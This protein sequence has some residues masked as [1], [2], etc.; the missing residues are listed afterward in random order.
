MRTAVRPHICLSMIVRNE[1][2][3]I[4]RCLTS[5]APIV[6]AAVLCDTGSTDETVRRAVACLAASNRPAAVVA[7]P[8]RDFG[9]NRT[10]ALKTARAFAWARGWPLERTYLLFLDADFELVVSSDFRYEQLQADA[11]TMCQ[12]SDSVSFWSLRLARASLDWRVVGATHEHYASRPAVRPERLESLWIR[13]HEDGGSRADK[14]TRDIRLLTQQLGANPGDPRTLFYLAQSYRAVG[15]AIKAL[16]LYRRR[17]ALG[18]SPEEVWYSKFAIGA[19][20][21]GAGDLDQAT[22]ALLDAA[23]SDPERAE[24]W[25]A[26]ATL[27]R[28]HGR[29]EEAASFADRGR[30]LPIPAARNAFIHREVYEG[31][32]DLELARAAAG[33]SRHEAGF[34][35]CE[36]LSLSRSAP[37]AVVDEA[38]RLELSYVRPLPGARFL[39][40]HPHLPAPYRPCNPGI[41]R[42]RDGYLVNCRAVNY[43]QRRLRYRP[44]HDDLVYRTENVLMSLDAEFEVLD[45]RLITIDAPPLRETRIRGLEDCRLVHV[46]GALFLMAATTDRHPSG[47][48]HQSLCHVADD[49]RVLS[50]LPLVGPFD[51]RVQKNWLPCAGPDGRLH[52]FYGYDPVTVLEVSAETGAYA[53]STSRAHGLNAGHWRGSAG[54]VVWPGAGGGRL[55]LLVHEAVPRQ[56]PDGHRDRVYLHRFVECDAGFAITRISRPFVFAHKGVEFAC[57]MAVTHD[58]EALVIGVGIEDRDACL[59]RLPITSVDALLRR[60]SAL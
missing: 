15:D 24:P 32:L 48:V 11:L 16:L 45:E 2:A 38:R 25:H 33:T 6:D 9:A 23:A 35:A 14:F 40:L 20:F 55:L 36:R 3:T 56:G 49:G 52:A 29:H 51:D 21:M 7:H 46:N 57:G 30:H 27:Y 34:D 47:R 59:C 42:T 22:P 53:V 1:Q 26:L 60:E 37:A 13:D 58:R 17:I 10:A 4:E 50:H 19:M 41:V 8:W 28:R 43:E 39:S 44:L 18:G 5:A 31:G 54:P 12:Q